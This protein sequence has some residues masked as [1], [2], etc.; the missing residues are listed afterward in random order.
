[1]T[2]H[3]L[4][5]R[6]NSII[7]HVRSTAFT[8]TVAAAVI[9]V[10]FVPG[11]P[12][13][14]ES[15]RHAIQAGQVWR[16]V[17]GYLTHWSLDHLFWDVLMFMVLGCVIEHRS[18]WRMI[19]LCLA[20]ALAISAG[21]AFW[22]ADIV[23]CRGLSGIDTALFTYAAMTTLGVAVTQKNWRNGL[24][25]AMLLAGFCGKVLYESLA[26]V[27]LFADSAS[28]GFHVVVEAHLIG[29]AIGLLAGLSTSWWR[30]EVWAPQVDLSVS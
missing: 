6:V 4:P 16:L 30:P 13:L 21:V 5:A 1:M 3:R 8:L 28:A 15:D 27:A 26:G 12:A 14:L 7:Q 17:T 22:R 25:A 29:A 2:D 10:Q 19:G 9:A 11:L 18:R 23:L 20:S 24:A